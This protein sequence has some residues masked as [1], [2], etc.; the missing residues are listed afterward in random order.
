MTQ[1]VLHDHEELGEA[2]PVEDVVEEGD[3][4]SHRLRRA[5]YQTHQTTKNHQALIPFSFL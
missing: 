3:V 4:L 2:H 1:V 5:P